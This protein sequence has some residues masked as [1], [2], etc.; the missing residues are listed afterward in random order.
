[1]MAETDVTALA[2]F[3]SSHA[4]FLTLA[5]FLV[6]KVA[7]SRS[8]SEIE[9]YLNEH[10]RDM[11]RQMFQD[12]LD[13]RAVEEVRLPEVHDADGVR[14]RVVERDHERLLATVFGKVTVRRL[15]YR[16]R[17]SAN[18]YP[19]DAVLNLPVE[20]HSH[21]LRELAAIESSGGSFDAAVEAMERAT[22]QEVGKRQVEELAHRAASDFE[23]FYASSPRPPVAT[24]GV[25]VL[26]VDGKGIVM[27]PDALRAATAASAARSSPKLATRLSRGE[28]RNR[29]RMAEVGAVY[30]ITPVPRTPA[31][32]L[33]VDADREVIPAPVAIRKWLTASVVDD[34]ALVVKRV[35]DE[36][37]RRDPAHRRPWVA[38]VDGNNH[39]LDR[40]QAE[41]RGRGLNLSIV[42]DFVHVMEYLW[43]AAWSF[44]AEG[45]PDAE[46]WVRDKALAVLRGG[47]STV[48]AAIR[49][50]ATCLGL[51][52]RTRA[53]A[54]TCADYLQR[55]C[56]YLD[57]PA[58]LA[59][60]WPI[61]TGVIEGAC[62]HL[63]KDR[64][65]I[66]GARWGL[67]GA[68]A[69]L[70]LRALRTNGDFPSYWAFHLAQEQRRV[71][72]ERYARGILPLAA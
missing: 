33:T 58:A 66:T 1:M 38:L 21:G 43:G 57:Y 55:K 14:H 40:I 59:H 54:D 8:H 39:Q 10:G 56:R 32:I 9:A 22:G 46:A 24:T 23:E 19:A 52:P 68:E 6:G 44:Y 51:A 26:S 60:G 28:K 13:E 63:V 48:A 4:Q 5:R 45:D 71:H 47:A 30:E 42:I 20:R 69:V 29:K 65:D 70:K 37:E 2:V 36:A 53:N 12:H 49:R 7:M 27:R 3:E 16:H 62:R 18:L 61:A 25:V 31:D 15:A 17:G 64:M 11:L 50:K 41:A 67:E 35:F 72:Q 34:A